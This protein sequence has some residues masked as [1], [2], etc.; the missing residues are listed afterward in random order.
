ME[1]SLATVL[2]EYEE[3][4]RTESLRVALVHDW[5]NGMRGGERVLEQV[6]ALFPRADLLTLL[7][8]PDKVSPVIAGMNVVE[9]PFA[10]IP[11]ARRHYRY[12]LP[13]MPAFVNWLPTADYDL[14]ISTSHCVA[15]GAP[16]PRQGRH[17]SY[18]FSPMRYVW[19]HFEDYLSGTWWKDAGLYGVR[20]AMQRWDRRSCGRVDA[21]AADSRH[22]AEKVRKFWGRRAET[23][24]PPVD[25][26]RF[27]PSGAPPE[28]FFLVVSAFVP[29]KKI[30]RAVE[31]ANLAGVRLVIVGGGPE[32]ERLRA[33]AGPTVEFAGR[34]ADDELADYYRRA[35]ALVFPGVEDFGITALESM[36]CGRPVLA[37]RGGG[38]LETVAEGVTG[39]F[40]DNPTAKSL[41]SV[42]ESHDDSHY[43]P[44]AIRRR[45]EEFS[46]GHFRDRLARWIGRET[47]FCW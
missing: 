13:L 35:R 27:Q 9:S 15:K 47:R 45:A 29:Y 40:F 39:A 8:E 21:F 42:L 24:Y 10:R 26:E 16:R 12:L 4:K 37:F 38:T 1:G 5:L 46:P 20:P 23:I 43:K 17:L 25:L 33:L 36:A 2:P 44:E 14:V 41:A 7:Y 19:D 18:I 34:V 3:L 32:E 22:I 6:C 30:D 11:G 28:D 31:A